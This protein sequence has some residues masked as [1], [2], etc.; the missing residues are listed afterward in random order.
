MASVALYCLVMGSV[1]SYARARAE[2]LGMQAKVGIAE[3]ADRLVSVLVVAG[4]SD[5]FGVPVA[6]D[7]VLWA[8]A[9][10]STI[11]VVQR[12]LVVRRQALA[13]DVA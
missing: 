2:S 6:L 8:L 1:T 7:V 10:A 12:M 9:V 5:L 11:T 13:G 4:L 3:R